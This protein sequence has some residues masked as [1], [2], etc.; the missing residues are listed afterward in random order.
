MVGAPR[1]SAR[2]APRG[3]VEICAGERAQ[4][5]PSQPILF[6]RHGATHA[7]VT[8]LRCGGDLDVPLIELGRRQALDTAHRIR[9]SRLPVGLVFTSSLLRSHE[10]ATI[11]SGELRG[12]E[13]AVEPALAERYLGAWNMRPISET[14]A[15]FEAGETPPGG[16]S[17]AV[18]IERVARALDNIVPRLDEQPLVVASKG[19]AR[20]ICELLDLEWRQSLSNGEI[21]C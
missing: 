6:V 16:E 9:D 17:N 18:F 20:A 21:A 12:V 5:S 1:A 4:M 7:N 2:A 3:A 11:I 14:Q 8:G 15:P 13:V 19:V 10:T